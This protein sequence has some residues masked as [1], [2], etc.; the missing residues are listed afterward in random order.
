MAEAVGS[1]AVAKAEGGAR[2]EAEA[3]VEAA[4]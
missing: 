1:A 3:P 2:V 4:A